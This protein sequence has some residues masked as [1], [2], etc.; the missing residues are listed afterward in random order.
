MVENEVST[1]FV[2]KHAIVPHHELTH[3]AA[4]MHSSP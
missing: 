1:K 4:D 3:H 2:C